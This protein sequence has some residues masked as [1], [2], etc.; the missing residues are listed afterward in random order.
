MKYKEI[1]RIKMS[2]DEKEF[3][4]RRVVINSAV[5]NLTFSESSQSGFIHSIDSQLIF[6]DDIVKNTDLI[7]TSAVESCLEFIQSEDNPGA[8]K[9]VMRMLQ[10]TNPILAFVHTRIDTK[11]YHA[12]RL[13]L[14]DGILALYKKSMMKTIQSKEL[15]EYTL[16]L[17]RIRC[18]EYNHVEDSFVTDVISQLLALKVTFQGTEWHLSRK[19]IQRSLF[20][21]SIYETQTRCGVSEVVELTVKNDKKPEAFNICLFYLKSRCKRRCIDYILEVLKFQDTHVSSDSL[22]TCLLNVA[23]YLQIEDVMDVCIRHI[24]AR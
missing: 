2:D 8:A 5:W 9:H 21:K 3:F 13:L 4:H 18:P 1:L 22:T 16:E 20:L 14:I 15:R 10:V 23:E 19:E 12:A 7:D 6:L 24:S 11:I 17:I